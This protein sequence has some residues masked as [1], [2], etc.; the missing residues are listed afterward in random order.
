MRAAD[1]KRNST[2]ERI[3]HLTAN[4]ARWRREHPE[5][6]SAHNKIA[7]A[8]KSGKLVRGPCEQCPPGTVGRV[9]GH[10]DDYSKPLDVRWLCPRHHAALLRKE[11]P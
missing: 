5:A 1:Q 4:S 11:R 3:A 7:R 10:H 2:P 9:H 6:V 8:I